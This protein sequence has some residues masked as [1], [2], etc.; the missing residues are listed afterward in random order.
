ME[1]KQIYK[2]CIQMIA[3]KKK[4]THKMLKRWKQ[5]GMKGEKRLFVFI[6]GNVKRLPSGR[7]GGQNGFHASQ[8]YTIRDAALVMQP[9]CDYQ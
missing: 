1:I 5:K 3:K 8:T 9:M 4:K 6:R 7:N 2:S